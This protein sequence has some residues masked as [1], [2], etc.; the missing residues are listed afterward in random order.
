[1]RCVIEY[2]VSNATSPQWDRS[3]Q[4]YV[5]RLCRRYCGSCRLCACQC[6]GRSYA[7]LKSVLDVHDLLFACMQPSKAL[8]GTRNALL[9][10]SGMKGPNVSYSLQVA[11][12]A[13][14]ALRQ[15]FRAPS[16]AACRKHQAAPALRQPRQAGMPTLSNQW[17]PSFIH[18]S[19]PSCKRC[20]VAVGSARATYSFIT[21]ES[22][23][24]TMQSLSMP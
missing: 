4:G 11:F 21:K 8:E 10:S 17:S 3:L 5:L 6:I 18:A 7:M 16:G 23:G 15:Y 20:H 13:T 1:M 24:Q 9:Q 12:H 19:T 14:A 2:A 22:P